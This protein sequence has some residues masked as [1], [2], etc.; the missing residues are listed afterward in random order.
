MMSSDPSGRGD[1]P[2]TV[3]VASGQ[4]IGG[5]YEIRSVIAH[6]GMGVVCEAMH[7][8]LGTLVAVKFIHSELVEDPN[9][10]QRFLN[11]ART[12]A[13]LRSEHI[14]RVYDAGRLDSG[15]PY[16]VME[17]LDG[18]GLD[19]LIKEEGALESADAVDFVLQACEGLAEAHA[20]G[21]VHRDIKPANLFLTRRPDGR[22]FVKVL[23]FG[24]SKR[25]ADVHLGLTDPRSSIGSPWYMSP[26][27]M[28]NA[29]SV[30]QRTD[31][32]SLGVV[33]FEL[34]TAIHP[35][36]GRTVTEVCSK[37]LTEPAPLLRSKRAQADPALEAIIS[38]CLEK[39]ADDRY[40]TV[41]SLA[42][43]LAP[44]GSGRITAVA[45]LPSWR[46]NSERPENE[47]ESTAGNAGKEHG[48]AFDSTTFAP[49]EGAVGSRRP[50]RRS[51][52]A[53]V[54]AIV[55]FAIGVTSTWFVLN[56]QSVAYLRTFQGAASWLG[57]KYPW[58]PVLG[59]IPPSDETS[60]PGSWSAPLFIASGAY[61]GRPLVRDA[62]GGSLVAAERELD[63]SV[64]D[65]EHLTL[66]TRPIERTA[67]P[68]E[69]IL[70]VEPKPFDPTEPDPGEPQ[71]IP[72]SVP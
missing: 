72:E 29:S 47:R 53:G 41:A 40:P 43:G 66:A 12:A 13:G 32:W 8:E 1:L 20:V 23:D 16:L 28:K 58:Q 70:P 69:R 9:M 31:I 27:Q 48:I 24:I 49:M 7:L 44:F 2:S 55:A 65:V 57:L 63:V 68:E 37:V 11:E 5:R 21:L 71:S 59:E 42:E 10:V 64:V 67:P 36:E 17:H 4:L 45:S 46:P 22:P 19:T 56:P 33:L 60:L 61:S 30:D 3:P 38:R 52:K 62:L 35:F 15:E 25:L 54:G 51:T 14:A 34:L 50:W 18:M 39:E 26:E 6:G